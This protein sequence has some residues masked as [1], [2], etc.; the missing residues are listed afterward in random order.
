VWTKAYLKTA[1]WK[2]KKTGRAIK[3]KRRHVKK[4]KFK[5]FSRTD[6][7]GGREK[8]E[9]AIRRIQRSASQNT[10]GR[11]EKRNQPRKAK[12]GRSRPKKDAPLRGVTLVGQG[13]NTRGRKA[14]WRGPQ[15]LIQGTSSVP[16]W[17][18]I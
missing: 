17:K 7:G 18:G 2:G 16:K 5:V 6:R 9:K 4:T 8:K 3:T 13:T 1:L 12:G 15:P 14:T 11:R 10:E